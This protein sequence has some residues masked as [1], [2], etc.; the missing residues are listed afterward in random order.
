MHADRARR[1]CSSLGNIPKNCGVQSDMAMNLGGGSRAEINI[2]PLI[3]VLLVLIIIF[4]IIQPAASKGLDATAP[5]PSSGAPAPP[6]RTI[7]VQLSADGSLQINQ[8]TVAADQLGARL[9]E[10]FKARAEKVCFI[11]ADPGMEF[12]EVA[13]VIEMVRDAGV[14]HVGLL[15]GNS[16]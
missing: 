10:I 4:M 14:V 15:G 12:Q 9:F 5:Q 11:R 13:K 16:N 1:S 3:D 7:V 6:A 8:E 2:T